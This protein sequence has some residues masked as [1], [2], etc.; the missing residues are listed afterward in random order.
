[1]SRATSII[2]IL[3]YSVIIMVLVLVGYI[4][5]VI[6]DSENILIKSLESELE[7]KIPEEYTILK[8]KGS[9]LNPPIDYEFL[10]SGSN[11]LL[12]EERIKGTPHFN[13]TTF[14]F[15]YFD[16]NQDDKKGFDNFKGM[17]IEDDTSYLYFPMAS[18]IEVLVIHKSRKTLQ[19]SIWHASN[20]VQDKD[21]VE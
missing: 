13:D 20:L 12:L 16:N 8:E 4:I 14:L 10:F 3:I 2:K 18:D 21:G 7:I 17:W 6:Y 1:M 5:T 19:A 11:F 9:L 15:K